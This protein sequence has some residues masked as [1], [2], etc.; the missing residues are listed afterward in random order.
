M[1]PGLSPDPSFQ[2]LDLTAVE[3]VAIIFLASYNPS[4]FGVSK[5]AAFISVLASAWG[6]SDNS[7]LLARDQTEFWN[8]SQSLL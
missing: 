5:Y 8:V 1:S 6:I 2:P 4:I 7:L 3:S